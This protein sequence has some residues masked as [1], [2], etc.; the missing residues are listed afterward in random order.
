MCINYRQ[1]TKTTK[2][3]EAA[4]ICG[5]TMDGHGQE[6]DFPGGETWKTAVS[7]SQDLLHDTNVTYSIITQQFFVV[8]LCRFFT[9]LFYEFQF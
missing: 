4:T 3:S 7:T 1:I 9:L 6:V 5:S 2:K 8:G